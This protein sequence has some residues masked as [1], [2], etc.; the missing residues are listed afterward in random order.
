[1]KNEAKTNMITIDDCEPLFEQHYEWQEEDLYTENYYSTGTIFHGQAAAMLEELG[2][3]SYS[4]S[5]LC[6]E[7]SRF[8]QIKYNGDIAAFIDAVEHCADYSPV[9]PLLK[10]YMM[11]EN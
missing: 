10:Y 7:L 6:D 2:L 8:A 9:A 3:A 1:M 11:N 5:H 4:I